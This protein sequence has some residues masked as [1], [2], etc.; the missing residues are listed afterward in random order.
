LSDRP[1]AIYLSTPINA[2]V[3]G[4]FEENVPFAEIKLHGDFGLGTL[5]DLDGEMMML[6]GMVYQINSE[7]RVKTI[8]DE[9]LTP[10]ACV[11]FYRSACHDYV[12]HEM[13]YRS[14]I[15]M[16]KSLIP[17]TNLF[18]AFRVEG[19]FSHIRTRSVPRQ[20]SYR[21]IVEATRDQ[22]TFDFQDIQGTIAG[23]FTPSFMASLNVPGFHLHFLSS[24]LKHG[25]H[26]LECIPVK[27][28]IGIQFI[29]KLELSLPMTL[30]YLTQDFNLNVE[31]DLEKVEK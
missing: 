17:S 20:E 1:S 19:T 26:L 24:D 22:S 6:D 2:L 15:D 13:D 23:F 11:T 27:A 16:L 25:G 30:D 9:A 3:E 10:F 21:P 5:N 31:K 4:I 7:G 8:G 28:E 18:Y 12:D 14:F 29:D